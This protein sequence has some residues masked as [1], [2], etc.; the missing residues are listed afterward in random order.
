MRLNVLIFLLLLIPLVSSA[1]V[2]DPKNVDYASLTFKASVAFQL[3]GV[4][5]LVINSYFLPQDYVDCDFDGQIL[6]DELGNKYVQTEVNSPRDVYVWNIS[7]KVVVKRKKFLYF[8]PAFPLTYGKEEQIYVSQTN[9]TNATQLIVKKANQLAMGRTDL[10]STLA[11]LTEFVH[12]YVKYNITLGDKIKPSSWVFQRRMGTC[13]EYAH[14]LLSMLRSLGIPA[15]YVAG[16]AYSSNSFQPH[17]WVEVRVGDEWLGVDPTFGEMSIDALHIKLFHSKDGAQSMIKTVYRGKMPSVSILWQNVSIQ[18]HQ[19]KASR[20]IRLDAN[21]LQGRVSTEGCDMLT[22][23]LLNDYPSYLPYSLFISYPKEIMMAYGKNVSLGVIDPSSKEEISYVFCPSIK[24]KKGYEYEFPITLKSVPGEKREITLVGK[25]GVETLRLDE[26]LKRVIKEELRLEYNLSLEEFSITP[27]IAYDSSP[28][29]RM[30]IKNEGN[31]PLEDF[32]LSVEYDGKKLF[33]KVG[34]IMIGE[35]KE[36]NL[37]LFLPQRY[38]R[39]NVS[40]FLSSKTFRKEIES[41]FIRAR[42]P[43]VNIN[44]EGKKV[45]RDFEKVNF[46]ITFNTES[47]SSMDVAIKVNDFTLRKTFNVSVGK[48]IVEL[49]WYALR[50]GSNTLRVE[51]MAVDGYGGKF[52]FQRTFRIKKVSTSFVN[53]LIMKVVRWAFQLKRLLASYFHS[54][55]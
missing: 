17:A 6:E 20:G 55:L 48:V 33:K 27:K 54:L 36:L 49:P 13:D 30:R 5:H 15:R 34:D 31:A 50:T 37:N 42:K 21:F 29:L 39:I 46:N 2:D 14:L 32:S 8:N 4:D 19:T 24:M 28:T 41:Y 7:C 11:K 52:Y 26:L 22:V 9:L 45:F 53:T 35:E 3:S 23:T 43:E 10:L 38:G 16:Y 40:V 1:D 25:E 12:H 44:Y 47:V 18:I 51:I